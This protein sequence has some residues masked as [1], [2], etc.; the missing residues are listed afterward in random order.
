MDVLAL[1]SIRD[2]LPNALL[3]GMAC[4]RAIVGTAVGGIPD[5]IG[6]G[7]NGRLVPPGDADALAHVISELLDDADLRQRLG[8]RARET[9]LR[10]FTVEQELEK[11]LALYRQLVEPRVQ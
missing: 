9:A 11:N 10:E 6:D 2:G 8:R 7:A 5:A 3:E 4:E 1:P